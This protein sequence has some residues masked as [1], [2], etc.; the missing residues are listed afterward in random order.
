MAR[1]GIT[2]PILP[3]AASSSRTCSSKSNALSAISVSAAIVGGKVVRPHQVVCLALIEEAD[4]VAQRV[5]QGV[6]LGAQSA[7]QAIAWSS[8]LFWAPALC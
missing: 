4:R 2:A 7:A 5:D 6:D 8:Q 1:G 3:A